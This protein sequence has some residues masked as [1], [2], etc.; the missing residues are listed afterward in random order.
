VSSTPVPLG[1]A[2]IS[3]VAVGFVTFLA[4]RW[5]VSRDFELEVDRTLRTDRIAVYRKLWALT[6]ALAFYGRG[7]DLTY[8]D[9]RDLTVELRGWY[10]TEGGILLSRTAYKRYMA[11]QD[12]LGTILE[13]DRARKHPG[14]TADWKSEFA[15][16]QARGSDLRTALAGDIGGRLLGIDPTVELPTREPELDKPGPA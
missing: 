6:E 1:S 12:Q 10:F 5:K 9:L 3:A 13:S 14:R 2:V 16:V 4:T 15:L 7:R 8:R 11:L